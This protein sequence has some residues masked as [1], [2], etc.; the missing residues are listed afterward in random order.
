M[1]GERAFKCSGQAGSKGGFHCFYVQTKL[2]PL[3]SAHFKIVKNGLELRK[4]Q[5]PQSRGVKNF[6][7]KTKLILEYQKNSLYVALLLLEF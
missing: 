1:V 3:L 7:F 4:L 2:E 6:F 5:S